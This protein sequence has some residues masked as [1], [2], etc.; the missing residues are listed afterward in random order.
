[1]GERKKAISTSQLFDS[2]YFYGDF[3]IPIRMDIV[4]LYKEE[5]LWLQN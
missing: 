4:K 1:M 3:L 2:V 5:K